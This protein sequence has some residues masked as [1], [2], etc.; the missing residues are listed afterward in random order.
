M[1]PYTDARI[2]MVEEQLIRRDIRDPHVLD[3]VRRVKRHLFVDQKY[4]DRAYDDTPL[5][6]PCSQTISQPYMVALM[7]Q[8]IQPTKDKT[9]LEVGTGSG[10]QTAI[11][12][13]TC[14]FVFSIERHPELA[15]Q[16][17]LLLRELGYRN[18]EIKVGDGSLGW[19]EKAPFDAIVVTAAAPEVPEK[20]VEQLVEKGKLVIP[21]GDQYRQHLQLILKRGD[22][23]ISK[24]ICGCVFVPLIGQGGWAE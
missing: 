19:P 9:V 12:A 2:R 6:I 22:S 23:Y 5:A 7:T 15:T 14:R 16:T 21:V 3:A 24:T 13:E 1:D 11:L 10:Y 20:L 8:L 17:E 18:I 4:W